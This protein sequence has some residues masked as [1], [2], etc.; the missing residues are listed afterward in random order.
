MIVS[1]DLAWLQA[2]SPISHLGMAKRDK[3][4]CSKIRLEIIRLTVI[5]HIR[6]RLTRRNVEALLQ[7]RG[8]QV[9]HEIARVSASRSLCG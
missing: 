3:F 7:Q 2:R 9:S 4:R 6:L 1:E 5:L 8:I